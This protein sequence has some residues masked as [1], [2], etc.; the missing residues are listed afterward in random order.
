MP[1]APSDDLFSREVVR[2]YVQAPRFVRRDWLAAEL[3]ERMDRPSCRF[4]L[5]TG[6]PGSGKSSFI[7]QIAADNPDSPVF[8]IRRDQRTAMGETSARSFLLRIGFQLAAC[9]P[10][11]FDLE[12]VRIE[13]EQQVGT[14]DD[15]VVGARIERLR[16]SPF[17]QTVVRITQRVRE[18]QGSLTGLSVGEWIADP[19]LIELDDLQELALLAPARIL[20]R[21]D[22]RARVVILVDALDELAFG[23]GE[24]NLLDWLAN[25]PSMPENVRIVLSSRPTH[26]WLDP[27]VS[28]R[29]DTLCHLR[30]GADDQRVRRDVS[31]YAFL[32][33]EPDAVV[34]ALREAG[35]SVESFVADLTERAAGN[36]GYAAA[37]GRAF[38]QALAAP[39]RR[40]LLRP[41]LRLDRL[42]DDVGKL[43]AFFLRVIQG[44]PGRNTIRATDTASGRG[45]LL[46]VWPELY[47]PMLALLSVAQQPLT[48]DQ[49]HG[50]ID[51][52][53]GRSHLAQAIGWLEQFL[54]RVGDG[55]RLYHVTF[56][57]FL[58]APAT[59]DAP[60]TS[61]LWVEAA[62]EH[63]RLSRVMEGEGWPDAIWQDAPQPREQGRRAYARL[64][65]VTHLFLGADYDRLDAVVEGGAYGRGKLRFD[66]STFLY[67]R[68][69]DLAIR[70]ARSRRADE[71]TRPRHLLRLWRFKLLRSALSSSA[72]LLPPAAYKALAAVGRIQEAADL[73]GLITDPERTALALAGIIAVLADE[74]EGRPQAAALFRDA[75]DAVSRVDDMTLRVTLARDILPPGG[76]QSG[77]TAVRD[78][79]L[80][81]ARSFPDVRHRTDALSSVALWLHGAGWTPDALAVRDEIEALSRS[82]EDR[83]DAAVAAHSA[84]VLTANLGDVALGRELAAVLHP[85]DRP[86]VLAVLARR[87]NTAGA[88]S[89]LAALSDDLVTLHTDLAAVGDP[90]PSGPDR[91]HA[92]VTQAE[93]HTALGDVPAAAF[94]LG[95]ALATLRAEGFHEH[96]DALCSLARAAGEAGL[97][98]AFD[99]VVEALAGVAFAEL[100]GAEPDDAADDRSALHLSV[101]AVWAATALAELGA[102]ELAL[103]IA[104]RVGYYERGPVL[105]A[106]VTSLVAS[107]ELDRALEVAE[108]LVAAHKEGPASISF[109]LSV[110]GVAH[111]PLPYSKEAAA[112][113]AICGGLARGRHWQRALDLAGGLDDLE[114]RIEALS[115]VAVQQHAAGLH[116]QAASLVARIM[117]EVR[118]N[119][120]KRDLVAGLAEAGH[121]CVRVQDWQRAWSIAGEIGATSWSRVN[122]LRGRLRLQVVTGLAEAGQLE[123]ATALCQEIERPDDRAESLLAMARKL[124]VLGSEVDN[125]EGS[126]TI[127]GM[128]IS[129]R[130]DALQ[131]RPLGGVLRAL[132]SVALAFAHCGAMDEA[133][134]TARKFVEVLDDAGDDPGLFTVRPTPWCDAAALFAGLG[135]WDWATRIVD[136]RLTHDPYDGCCA[137]LAMTNAA[138]R[139]GDKRDERAAALIERARREA[140]Q[141]DLP[142]WRSEVLA[143]VA[144]CS[145]LN[146]QSDE[147]DLRDLPADDRPGAR[148]RIS[149]SLLKSDRV[150]DALRVI[151]HAPEELEEDQIAP[152]TFKVLVVEL[153]KAEQTTLARRIAEIIRDPDTKAEALSLV[154]R[155]LAAAGDRNEVCALVGAAGVLSRSADVAKEAAW[156]LAEAGDLTALDR[157][158]E[159][160]WGDENDPRKL[161]DLVPMAEPLLARAPDA[162]AMMHDAIRWVEATLATV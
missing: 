52:V 24:G 36:I 2:A 4:V 109:R 143:R 156:A 76:P 29:A 145:M 107:N 13:V 157:L 22:P 46:E 117:R 49:L 27:F 21:L 20:A 104:R 86:S 75:C 37:V 59:R 10:E 142:S 106:I 77:G 82:A 140:A 66:P 9:R 155:R 85:D 42:P 79:A 68:D 70:A 14:A 133:I 45:V 47:H 55:Y 137:L 149:I 72:N 152:S 127:R 11:L 123:S 80:A 78:A 108:E 19:R 138:F 8:F 89:D 151:E 150:E 102:S 28:R 97:T 120:L 18:A 44:G 15:G 83:W 61:D 32:L 84:A 98:M 34:A 26:R 23:E 62:L 124:R 139:S 12:Q 33:V 119:N 112:F 71:A 111:R 113:V 146:R 148:M 154:A 58:T 130:E 92:A 114:P 56:A 118:Q 1:S 122:W 95:E 87:A 31:T 40:I 43:F 74:P 41:L 35:R 39:E 134:A 94:L 65:Y 135:D 48:L 17:H 116:D 67:A 63:R 100:D 153:L 129:A 132:H 6:E 90:D 93:L 121:L 7:A 105:L 126:K 99:A 101:K 161:L 162:G 50:L 16:A 51:T 91:A 115:S 3:R 96:L 110:P 160:R 141:I 128:L 159:E 64:H 158:V 57:E 54:D 125:S 30:L 38:D 69:L 60:D 131:D 136:G 81:L 88:A 73:A 53:A 25:G 144:A 103:E 5:L 147:A